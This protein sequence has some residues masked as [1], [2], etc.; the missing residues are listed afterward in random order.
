MARKE[1]VITIKD[2][3]QDLKFRIREMPMTEAEDWLYR[4]IIVLSPLFQI[5]DISNLEDLF[6]KPE[7]IL[8]ALG[9]LSKIDYKEAK[10]LYDKL[11]ECAVRID[12]GYEQKCTI[13]TVN[14]YVEN[15]QT[16]V[17]IRLEAFKLHHFFGEGEGILSPSPD[18]GNTKETAK[19][20]AK[21]SKISL[22]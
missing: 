13:D 20:S 7:N 4:A 5:T 6:S 19:S 22:S 18:M 9:K 21:G 12:A 14:A 17:K 8:T 2:R 1:T 11:L 15:Y 10:Y 3:T 16:L